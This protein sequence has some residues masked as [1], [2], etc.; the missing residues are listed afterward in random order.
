MP[1]NSR[2]CFAKPDGVSGAGGGFM[3]SA[4]AKTHWRRAFALRYANAAPSRRPVK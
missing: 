3:L 2:H 1:M 4:N